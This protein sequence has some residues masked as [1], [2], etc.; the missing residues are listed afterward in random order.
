MRRAQAS[1]PEDDDAEDD[2]VALLAGTGRFAVIRWVLYAFG[3]LTLLFMPL[4]SESVSLYLQRL[5]FVTLLAGASAMIGGLVG[6]LFGIPRRMQ[7]EAP[8]EDAPEGASAGARL[9]GG[10]TNLEQI[11]DWLT[12]ILVG[13]GLTQVTQIQGAFA[14]ISAAA[15]TGLPGS[16]GAEVFAVCLILYFG[17]GGFILGYLWTRLY[18]GQALAEA[19]KAQT[20]RAKARVLEAE[21]THLQE[22]YVPD[23]KALEMTGR[24]L[25]ETARERPSQAELD[26]AIA[27][28]SPDARSAVWHAAQYRRYEGTRERGRRALVELTAPVFRALLAS[29][30]GEAFHSNHGQLGFVLAQQR[31]PD[32]AAAERHL[33][34]AIRIRDATGAEDWRDYERW[35]AR[36]RIEIDPAF[37]EGRPSEDA[38]RADIVADLTA[39]WKRGGD[40]HDTTG[41]WLALNG[42]ALDPETGAV[43]PAAAAD[44]RD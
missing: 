31:Q 28:A 24:Q 10:N 29:D 7:G 14:T 25:S 16:A 5:A 13:V 41:R 6:L 38:V 3:V 9:Y 39:G 17:V 26:A 30:V 36:A 42:L 15:A 33:S 37:A 35:R 43:R 12:K 27:A 21:L 32:W 19:E 8:A 1:A 2:P 44:A 20:L 34:E 40:L 18:L 22:A 4:G 23:A 11:S